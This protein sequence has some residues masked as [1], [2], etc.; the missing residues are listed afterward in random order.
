MA[1]HINSDLSSKSQNAF[2]LENS[3]KLGEKKQNKI[4]Y[5]KYEALYLVETKKAAISKQPKLSNKERLNYILFKDLRKKGYIVKTGLKFGAEFRVYKNQKQKTKN[6]HAIW[7]AQTIKNSE[8]LNL[9]D[10]ISKNRI[11]HTTGKKLLLA[12]IDPQEDITYF[13]VSWTK[14]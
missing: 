14:P 2:T 9:K 11:A 10:F 8:K 3:K 5:S 7:L 6:K 12:I 13:E 4:I 1:I